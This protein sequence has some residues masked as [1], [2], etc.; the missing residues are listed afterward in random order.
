MRYDEMMDWAISTMPNLPKRRTKML[1]VVDQD[2]CHV[3][4][5]EWYV[6]DEGFA[7]HPV[8]TDEIR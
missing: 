3:C 2:G 4:W 7:T 1:R 6:D 5:V 8:D